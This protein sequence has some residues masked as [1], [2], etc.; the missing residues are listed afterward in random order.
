MVIYKRGRGFELET[1]ENKSSKW[2]GRF[3]ESPGNFSGP[4]SN[5]LIEI[6]RVRAQIMG[7]KLL[8]FVSIADSFIMLIQNC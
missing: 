2:R 8:H 3:L 4:K 5:I 6:Q 7:S 1:T